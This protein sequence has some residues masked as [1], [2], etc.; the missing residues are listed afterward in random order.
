MDYTEARNL[1][2]AIERGD[3]TGMS[4]MFGIEDEEWED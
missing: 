2:S 4:F 1:Y 3:I